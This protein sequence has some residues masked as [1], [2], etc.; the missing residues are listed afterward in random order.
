M[1]SFS[2]SL[3]ELNAALGIGKT[4][5]GD[6]SSS[7]E[8]KYT[9]FTASSSGVMFSVYT[10]QGLI[11][12]QLE[13]TGLDVSE[14][15]QFF[16]NFEDLSRI[17]DMFKGLRVTRVTDITIS[18]QEKAILVSVHEEPIDDE[19]GD[20]YSNTSHFRLNA[21][22]PQTQAAEAV[23]REFPSDTQDVG[24]LRLNT[25]ISAL[26]PV[27]SND[28]SA[29]NSATMYFAP[30]FIFVMSSTMN[31]M[32]IN[33]LPEAFQGQGIALSYS[34]VSAIKE[35]TKQSLADAS[36][37]VIE[38]YDED[39]DFDSSDENDPLLNAS[40]EVARLEKVNGATEYLALRYKGIEM[41]LR[42]R[43]T[44]MPNYKRFSDQIFAQSEDGAYITRQTGIVVNRSYFKDVIKRMAIDKD[45]TFEFDTDEGFAKV[46]S[47]NYDQNIP[48]DAVKGDLDEVV[49]SISVPIIS[50]TI[51]GD[52]STYSD[53]VFMYISMNAKNYTLYVMDDTGV[54]FSSVNVNKKKRL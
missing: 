15:W 22:Q 20:G 14:P 21:L 42:P 40:V 29:S 47:K 11:R 32:F 12:T 26:Q 8:S 1:S 17:V 49:F 52:D 3:A 9:I 28:A 33:E 4:I 10:R 37:I 7:S 44:A 43:S 6:K 48:L 36:N 50:N 39:I 16:V 45:V 35:L 19:M 2:I 5:L 13:V 46:S 18:S 34:N 41:M 38:D 54:W 30:D 23:A 51:L 53:S 25:Y 24:A 27:M 31:S